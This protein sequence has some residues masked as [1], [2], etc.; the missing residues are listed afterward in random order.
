[1]T[2]TTSS[3]A[4]TTDHAERIAQ[5]EQNVRRLNDQLVNAKAMLRE[6]RGQATKTKSAPRDCTCGCGGTTSG[7]NFLPGHDAR[8]RSRLLTAIRDGATPESEMAALE[9]LRK[10]PKLL[11][12]VGDWDLGRDRKAREA[13][14]GRIASAKADKA[15]RDKEEADAKA[16]RAKLQAR[17]R[18]ETRQ[19]GEQRL[20]NKDRAIEAAK[21]GKM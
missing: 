1:M 19:A 17:S 6:L 18:E 20:A 5:A 10:F 9:E 2:N 13:K 11:H 12:G 4:T 7:G 21:S 16:A 3:N 14:E 8:M 15:A